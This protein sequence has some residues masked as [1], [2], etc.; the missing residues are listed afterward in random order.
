MSATKTSS[1]PS[2][3]SG[4]ITLIDQGAKIHTADQ[5][6]E[7]VNDTVLGSLERPALAWLARHMPAWITPDELTAVGLFAAFVIFAGYVLTNIDHN[8]LW[9][10]SFGFVLNW[11]GDSL[12]GTLARMRH[13]E[14]PRYGYFVDHTVDAF[15]EVLIFLGLGLSPYLNFKYAALALIGYMLLSVLVYIMTYVEGVFRISYIRL[16]PTEMRVT[17]I[18]ANAVV[19]FA[20]NPKVQLPLGTF[21]F[22]DLVAVVLSVLFFGAYS[23]MVVSQARALNRMESVKKKRH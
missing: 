5:G 2:K 1:K 18:L 8:F 19:F 9:L 13:I 11:F 17:A 12:D 21:T 10:A 3:S 4:F 20:G 23:V 6:H 14:R 22:Y 16:G 7:R 15:S